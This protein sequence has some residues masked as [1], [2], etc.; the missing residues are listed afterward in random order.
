M[1]FPIS[2][3]DGQQYT[4]AS[5]TL[6]QY[7]AVKNAWLIVGNSAIL[8]FQPLSQKG[9][10][11]GYAPLNASTKVPIDFLPAGTLQYVSNWDASI[12]SPT[13]HDGTGTSGQEYSISVTGVQDLGQGDTTYF[14]GTYL[15]YDGTNYNSTP[16]GNTVASVN[17]QTGTVIIPNEVPLY[18]SQYCNCICTLATDT[19]SVND[20]INVALTGTGSVLGELKNTTNG[21]VFLPEGVDQ[22]GQISAGMRIGI[23]ITGSPA[24]LPTIVW[25]N[26]YFEQE[27]VTTNVNINNKTLTHDVNLTAADVGADTSGNCLYLD[28]TTPQTVVNGAPDFN[29]GIL[30]SA[31]NDDGTGIT[32]TSDNLNNNGSYLTVYANST[33]VLQ[34]E[35][36]GISVE[37]PT[38]TTQTINDNGA[39]IKVNSNNSDGGPGIALQSNSSGEGNVYLSLQG[40]NGDIAN[41]QVSIC[42]NTSS[43]TNYV[44]IAPVANFLPGSQPTAANAGDVYYDQ[45][46]NSLFQYNGTAWQ[47][48]SSLQ[49]IMVNTNQTGTKTYGSIYQNTSSKSLFVQISFDIYNNSDYV[50]YAQL[51][52]DS[53][54]TP[55]TVVCQ[56]GIGAQNDGVST[57]YVAYWV[58][59]GDYYMLTA[60]SNDWQ[61]TIWSWIESYMT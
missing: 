4:N 14:A 1:A 5:G 37:I 33:P 19:T 16:N 47:I 44:Q 52:S 3:T 28:Q 11:N 59:P 58:A 7:D 50:S 60:P 15:I 25:S 40:G 23:L 30:T 9:Q 45:S 36:D 43:D 8:L 42:Q 21:N 29:A 34:V 46:I 22:I 27:A 38:I 12:N 54:S 24:S 32:I 51:L 56:A 26:I 57:Q 2:P 20:M 48:L 39:G 61:T 31:I 10:V 41:G 13:L 53:S 17:N 49:G 18:A 55:T 6:Y 35:S